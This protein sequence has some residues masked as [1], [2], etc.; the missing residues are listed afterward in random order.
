FREDLLAIAHVATPSIQPER[1]A[2]RDSGRVR[3]MA[4]VLF[5]VVIG[6][7]A[8][9]AFSGR[10][11]LLEGG[12]SIVA[13]NNSTSLDENKLRLIFCLPVQCNSFGRGLKGLEDCYCCGNM[14]HYGSCYLTVEQCRAHC[15]LCNPRCSPM[16]PSQ[17]T[18]DTPMNA[19]TNTS[20]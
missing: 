8:L 4:M 11:Q 12:S 14:Y 2:M 5:A 6:C 1:L 9:P 7:L 10:P 19:T 20:L 15:P 18:M 17:S 16:P 13:A 3:G